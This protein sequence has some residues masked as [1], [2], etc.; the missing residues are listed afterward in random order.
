LQASEKYTEAADSL[1]IALQKIFFPALIK[2]L[3]NKFG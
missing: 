1:A 2:I 3:K